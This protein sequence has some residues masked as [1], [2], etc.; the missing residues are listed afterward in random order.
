LFAGITRCQSTK[1]VNRL[2]AIEIAPNFG[3]SQHVA[4]G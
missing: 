3:A 4:L 2:A 1:G